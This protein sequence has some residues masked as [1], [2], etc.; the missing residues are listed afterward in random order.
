MKGPSI[1]GH[2]LLAAMFLATSI[3][4][5]SPNSL[6]ER[7]ASC[8]KADHNK[9]TQAGLP[10]NFCC[11][12]NSACISL[13]GNTTVLCCP[14]GSNCSTIKP[15]TCDITAQNV[16]KNPD[17]TLKTT[18]LNVPLLTCG[19]GGLCCPFGFS[20][21]GAGNC[22][23]NADQNAV[24]APPAS[25]P[26][27]NPSSPT[28]PATTSSKPSSTSTSAPSTNTPL[29]VSPVCNKFPTTAVLA[30]FFPGLALGILLSVAGVCI[31]GSRRRKAARRRSGSSFGNVS[32]RNI[33]DPQPS[34]DMRTDFLRKPPQTPSTVVSSPERRH[35]VQRMKSIFRKSPNA[36]GSPRLAP[37][38]PLN[39]SRPMAQNNRPVTP[40]LQREPSYEDINIFADDHTASSLRERERANG[41]GNGNANRNRNESP[42]RMGR[43]L[44]LAP[45]RVPGMRDSHQTTFSDMMERSGLAG[46]QKGQPYVY[47]R[48]SP[49][50]SPPR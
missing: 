1:S 28:S 32:D 23:M 12:A 48:E 37:P 17:N 6:F 50:Y 39:V 30:G 49:G 47:K 38:L 15:I 24:P 29:V 2:A 42:T 8:P 13:A 22:V 40:V 21:N 20:C 35:T 25:S 14:T 46:L 41:M 10:D 3:T 18:A 5:R 19:G 26:S 27:S 33:S 44:G 4:A 34:K 16:T 7:Q 11:P 45:P 9:C 43:G 36:N 31:L